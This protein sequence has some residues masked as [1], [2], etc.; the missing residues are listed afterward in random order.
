MFDGVLVVGAGLAGSEAAWQLA[1]RGARVRLAEMRPAVMTPAHHTARAA[2]LVCTNSFKSDVPEVAA[3]LLHEELRQLGSLVLRAADASRVPS[4][5]DLSVDRERFADQVEAGLAS[6]GVERVVLEVTAID[7][8]VPTIVASGPL[9]SDALAAELRRLT[10]TEHLHFYDAAAPIVV[11]ESLDLAELFRASRYDKGAGNYLN[12][13]MD[14]AGYLGFVAALASAEQVE[15][16]D[17]EGTA[18]FEGCIPIEEMA[19]RG[20]E[21]LR[22]G[23]LKPTGLTDPRTGRWPHAVVQLRQDDAAA[24]LYNLVGFQTNLRWPAQRRI[25]RTIP[26]LA[27]AEFARLGVMHRNTYVR[28][29]DL[30]EPSHRLRGTERTWLAGQLVGVEGYLE[31]AMSGLVAALNVAAALGGGS[32]VVFPADTAIG[33]LVRYI[34]TPQAAFAPMNA[35]WGLFPPLPEAGARRGRRERAAAHLARARVSLAAYLAGRPDLALGAGPV[36]GTPPSACGPGGRPASRPSASGLEGR[37]ASRPPA[38][39][40]QGCP[41]L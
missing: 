19:R 34:T 1:R 12:A 18:W 13:P 17:F 26:G 32:P 20:P 38:C 10:G 29:P 9:T 30:L 24:G 16:H 25:F 41:A 40:P 27:K 22:H 36:D 39:G 11:G 8:D 35:T 23:P 28:S 7:P 21:T 15:L 3:G 5:Q 14:R 6:A 2:E 33:S 4:G 37:S 31:S